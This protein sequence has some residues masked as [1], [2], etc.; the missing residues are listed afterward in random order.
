MSI[1]T[2]VLAG[3]LSAAMIFA[4]S[5]A[6]HAIIEDPDDN[7]PTP[8][9]FSVS[10]PC[11]IDSNDFPNSGAVIKTITGLGPCTLTIDNTP[12][13]AVHN[14]PLEHVVNNTS[15]V[16]EGFRFD[17]DPQFGIEFV[18]VVDQSGTF[19]Q[20]GGNAFSAIFDAVGAGQGIG[21]TA[22]WQF[23]IADT[24]GP[25]LTQ[26]Q[27]TQQAIVPE[28]AMVGLL[29]LGLVGLGLASRRRKSPRA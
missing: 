28:P 19:T 24:T 22:V 15:Y 7:N 2:T 5:N 18:S 17:I 13:N 20:V 26:L 8:P 23:Q 16:W 11:S 9:E 3:A 27:F 21:D 14:P 29:G 25:S 1:R 6:A 10:G 4:L 12:V